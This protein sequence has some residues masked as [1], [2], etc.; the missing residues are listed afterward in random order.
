M[1]LVDVDEMLKE[2]PN[3]RS[4]AATLDKAVGYKN[5][6]EL[7]TD[8]K[9]DMCENYCKIPLKYSKAEWEDRLENGDVIECDHC[10]LAKL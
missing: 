1:K 5:V 4:L 9:I 7:V 6:G 3:R 10:P 8:I 2:Y